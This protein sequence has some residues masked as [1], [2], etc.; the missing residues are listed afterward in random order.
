MITAT[1]NRPFN[2]GFKP[3]DTLFYNFLYE[4]TDNGK[5]FV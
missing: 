3:T 5:M 2:H 1:Y 4:Y